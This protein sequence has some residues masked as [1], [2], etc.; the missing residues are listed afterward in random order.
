MVL[1]KEAMFLFSVMVVFGFFTTT[2]ISGTVYNVGDSAG[3][4]GGNVD[5]HMWASTKTFQ[6]GDTLVFQYN[7]QLHNVVRVSLSDFHLCNAF[8]PIVT[9]STGNDTITINGPGHFY[10]ICGFKGHCQAGQKV[11]IRVP[12]PYQLTDIRSASATKAPV[13][14]SQGEK[15]DLTE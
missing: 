3:W 2:V 7:Q 14:A 8:N 12:K 10:Y 4:N 9:Y 15:R 5:Y 11:D 1:A 6:V 13:E